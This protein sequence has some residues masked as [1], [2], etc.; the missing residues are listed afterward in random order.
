M[1]GMGGNWD[2]V[3]GGAHVLHGRNGFPVAV[4][5]ELEDE[6]DERCTLILAVS[7]G[8]ARVF[9]RGHFHGMLLT[10][11][12]EHVGEDADAGAWAELSQGIL[13]EVFVDIAS[14]LEIMERKC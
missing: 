7:Q 10:L 12:R 11:A 14:V 3:T 9:L 4:S 1:A 8:T 13:W 5:V 6:Q 2:V